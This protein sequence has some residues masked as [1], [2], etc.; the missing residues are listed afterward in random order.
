MESMV[1]DGMPSTLW[2]LHIFLST[3]VGRGQTT[4]VV[5]CHIRNWHLCI[6]SIALHWLGGSASGTMCLS[7]GCYNK[8]EVAYKQ[9]KFI[10]HPSEDW[11]S[12]VR[13]PE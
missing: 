11:K 12:E 6:L 1:S 7:S 2:A 10:S 9:Q 13:V 5:P 4:E 8:C 3:H